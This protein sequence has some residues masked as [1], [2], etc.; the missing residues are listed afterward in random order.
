MENAPPLR[1]KVGM[2]AEASG[3]SSDLV[4]TPLGAGGL[5]I[6]NNGMRITVPGSTDKGGRIF[7]DTDITDITG[8]FSGRRDQMMVDVSPADMKAVLKI[9]LKKNKLYGQAPPQTS[10]E[11]GA[12][13]GGRPGGSPRDHFDGT[14][15]RSG[16]D[17]TLIIK[18]W[19]N[20]MGKFYDRIADATNH[21]VGLEM[22][23]DL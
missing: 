1:N 7:L 10:R 23:R 11:P 22:L 20:T 5:G 2:R 16:I 15:F 13:G 12:G 3:L 9:L 19:D 18:V 21:F 6:S 14:T 4:L 8:D 17:P